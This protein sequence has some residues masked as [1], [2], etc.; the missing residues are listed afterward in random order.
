MQEVH[1][2]LL[3]IPDVL[4]LRLFDYVTLEE[5]NRTAAM[6][7]VRRKKEWLAARALLR[8]CLAHCTNSDPLALLLDKTEEGKPVLVYPVMPL[9][10][11]VSHGLRWVACAV[12]QAAAIGVD[13]EC[14]TRRN[15]IDD[16]AENYFHPR[17]QETMPAIADTQLR[18]SEFFRCWT[19]KEAFIK[20]QGKT[21]N[22]ARLREIA[23][24]PLP[25][26]EQQEALFALPAGAWHF[27]HKKFDGDHHLALASQQ[28]KCDTAVQYY[29]WQWH[30]E[31]GDRRLFA[32][33]E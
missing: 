19:L 27:A 2:W 33:N 13:V 11:N 25:T 14:E 24:A 26:G 16:I 1:V 12:S 22:G 32:M 30:P 21:L 20:A 9:A 28:A 29:F 10:F 31:T 4:P 15:R 23:F 3:S 6:T 7:S 18:S 8:A 17:E 5:K